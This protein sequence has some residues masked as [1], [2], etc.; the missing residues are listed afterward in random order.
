MNTEYRPPSTSIVHTE[1]VQLAIPSSNVLQDWQA[2]ESSMR[3]YLQ[4]LEKHMERARSDVD[5]ANKLREPTSVMLSK[6]DLDW[7]DLKR[8]FANL[9]EEA[10][11]IMNQCSSSCVELRGVTAKANAAATRLENAIAHAKEKVGL[12]GRIFNR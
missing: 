4:D 3:Y 9:T 12:I 6:F 7:T 5:K 8:K 2:L 11:R 1:K 10:E